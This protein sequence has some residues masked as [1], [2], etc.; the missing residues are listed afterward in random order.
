MI[1]TAIICIVCVSLPTLYSHIKGFFSETPKKKERVESNKSIMLIAKMLNACKKRKTATEK[2]VWKI[3][4]A[5]NNCQNVLSSYI[6]N[7][8]IHII[9]ILSYR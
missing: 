9:I 4:E 2:E 5:E 6:N 3:F 1:M 7:I 8:I